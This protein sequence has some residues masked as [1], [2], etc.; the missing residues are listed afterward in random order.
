MPGGPTSMGVELMMA[1]STA[2]LL[3]AGSPSIQRATRSASSSV[4]PSPSRA[5]WCLLLRAPLDG[6]TSNFTMVV[7]LEVQ[8]LRFFQK[9]GSTEGLKATVLAL[10]DRVGVPLE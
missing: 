5:S 3:R 6:S 9:S 1:P 4:A 8:T 10:Q 2:G 7:P